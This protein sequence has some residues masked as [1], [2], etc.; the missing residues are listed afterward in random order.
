[1][2][3]WSGLGFMVAVIAGLCCLAA[4]VVTGNVY[5]DPDYYENHGW[6]KLIG[7]LVAALIVWLMGRSLGTQSSRVLYDPDT[8]EQFE[9][10]PNHTLFFIPVHW[11]APILAAIGLGL[12]F[13]K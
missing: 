6:P 12:A 1:M 13:Q 11:W 3:V 5:G 9:F 8:G 2:I 4:Q 10:R 7:L